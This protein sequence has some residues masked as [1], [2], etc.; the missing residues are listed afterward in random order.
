MAWDLRAERAK[1]QGDDP[2]T[3]IA[4]VERLY[5]RPIDE[6]RELITSYPNLRDVRWVQDEPANMGPWPHFALH[7]PVELADVLD[8]KP[9]MPG[10]PAGVVVPGRGPGVAAHR[11]AEGAAGRSASS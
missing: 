1:R 3:A 10:L 8:G 4:T 2:T 11:G 7:L 5:P 9:I 6:L